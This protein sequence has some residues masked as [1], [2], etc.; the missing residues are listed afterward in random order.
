MPGKYAWFLR[1]ESLLVLDFTVKITNQ[2]DKDQSGTARLT[3]SDA[4]TQKDMSTAL[5]ITEPDRPWS[6]P[7]RESRVLA[8]RLSAPQGAGLL[9]YKALATSGA[10]SDGE[11]GLLPVIPRRVMLTESLQLP[12]RDAGSKDFKFKKLLESRQSNTL[13]SRM[14]DVQV[15]SQPAWYAVMALPYLMEF[16]HDCAEQTFNRYYANALARH[17]ANSDPQIRRIFELWKNTR[18]TDSPLT[19]NADLKGIP[20]EETPW[21]A[22]AADSSRTRRNLG[23]LFDDNRIENELESILK[24][25]CDMQGSD[26]LSS[27]L[28]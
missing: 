18:A 12:I 5:G 25:L 28:T 10:L 14:L 8:W 26:G 9:S 19:K 22:K 1:D 15:V 3:M 24:K 21:L 4:T 16:P 6:I 7:A 2:S 20:L 17:I 11:E 13:E 23:I 27:Q